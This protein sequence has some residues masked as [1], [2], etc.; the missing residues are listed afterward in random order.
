MKFCLYVPLCTLCIPDNPQRL[1]E[2][3][4]SL[5]LEF[6][7]SV[8]HLDLWVLRIEPWSSGGAVTVFDCY[9]VFPDLK[10]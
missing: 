4:R 10:V 6:K 1:E 3:L 8:S 9:A 5:V 2:G 7:I